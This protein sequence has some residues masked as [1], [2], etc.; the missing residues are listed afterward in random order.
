MN[1]TAIAFEKWGISGSRVRRASSPRLV[2]FSPPKRASGWD[3]GVTRRNFVMAEAHKMLD[4]LDEEKLPTPARRAVYE[5]L[6][7]V[8]N[9]RSVV[10]SIVPIGG[11]EVSLN[12]VVGKRSIEVEICATGPSYLWAIDERGRVTSIESDAARIETISRAIL[13]RMSMVANRVNPKWRRDY[14]KR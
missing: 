9:A 4:G 11:G 7:R 8:T 13:N 2:L 3:V 10:P 5:F 6:E 14:L 1:T 12:W